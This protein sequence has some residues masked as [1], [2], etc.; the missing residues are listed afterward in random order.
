MYCT[1]GKNKRLKDEKVKIIYSEDFIEVSEDGRKM[2]T[3]KSENLTPFLMPDPLLGVLQAALSF[4]PVSWP[5]CKGC[6]RT[7]RPASWLLEDTS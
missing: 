2:R 5:A 6:L 3:R 7:P 4:H 1:C